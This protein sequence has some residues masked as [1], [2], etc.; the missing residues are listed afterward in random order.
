MTQFV[1][2]TKVRSL[3][4]DQDREPLRS[5]PTEG[6]PVSL[7]YSERLQSPHTNLRAPVTLARYPHPL[8][9][10]QRRIT[11]SA[12]ASGAAGSQI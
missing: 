1:Q 2:V 5:L 4:H 6:A 9:P 12:E 7:T 10:C 3:D 11:P 8:L